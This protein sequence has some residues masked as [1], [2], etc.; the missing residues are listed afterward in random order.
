MSHIVKSS[1]DIKPTILSAREIER[2]RK[3]KEE[4]LKNKIQEEVV[5]VEPEAEL[6]VEEVDNLSEEDVVEVEA[7]EVVVE[8]EAEVADEEVEEANT[9][10]G[11]KVG[12]K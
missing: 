6:T 1:L 2:L 4:Y 11:K 7:E 12:G 10:K 8:P 5:V 3:E 9:K